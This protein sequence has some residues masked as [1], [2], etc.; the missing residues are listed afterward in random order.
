[1]KRND[2]YQFALLFCALLVIASIGYFVYQELF[3]EYKKYQKGYKK[4]EIFRSSYTGEKPA[5]FSLG[6]KQILLSDAKNGPETI[7]R[8]ISCHVAVDL[9]H[10]SKESP[11]YIWNK[12]VPENLRDYQRALQMHPLFKGESRPFEFHPLSE[13][14]CTSCHGGNGRSLVASRAHGPLY[15]GEYEPAYHTHKPEFLESDPANDPSFAQM[16]NAKPG[17]E[18]VFQ[19]TPLLAGPLMGA[20]CA[21]CHVGKEAK[22]DKLCL[23]YERGKELFRSQACYACHRISGYSRASIGPELT[24]AGFNYPWYIKESIVWP[25]A[26]LPSSTMPNFRLD[27]EEVADLM[28]FLM[29][30][31]GENTPICEA[32]YM[33]PL[34]KWE[35]GAKMPW[36]KALVGNENG[37]GIFT[38][39]GCAACHKLK[40]S[41]YSNK[42]FSSHFPEQLSGSEIVKLVNAQGEAIDQQ[43]NS[44]PLDEGIDHA[45]YSNFKFAERAMNATYQDE[46]EKLATYKTRLEKVFRAYVATYGIGREIAPPLNWSG[47]YR[48]DAWLMG[49]FL[50][51]MAYTPRSLMPVFPFDSSKFKKLSDMLHVYGAQNRD[52]L[53][54]VWK[55]N[56]FNPPLA[57]SLLCSSC[58]GVYRQGNGPIAEWIYPIPKNLKNPIFLHNLTKERAIDSILHGVQGTPMPPWGEGEKP[59]LTTAQATQL[60]D[61]LYQGLPEGREDYDKW[62]YS[63]ADFAEEMRRDEDYFAVV[64]NSTG[65]LDHELYYFREKYYTPENLKKGEE[66]FLVNCATCHGADGG[67][68]GLRA[69]AMIEAKPRMLNNLPWLKSR[70]DLRLLRSIK[71]G[72]P[73]TAMTPW[74]DMTTAEQRMQLVLFIRQQQ[75]DKK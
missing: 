26:D 54:E 1:M 13:Y 10:F 15:D 43:L 58:H 12:N 57:Y 29:A 19:T 74:G 22:V 2:F 21:Q 7:D 8:C 4:L 66:L 67:G 27:H 16:Y 56:G 34:R 44:L 33:I 63:A 24:Y 52:S 71:Y 42:W 69:T 62:S 40:T 3:P 17:H 6:I 68:N 36:E 47:V 72:V 28:A 55:L 61:W 75:K 51:P 5:P 14:G 73:G 70:D 50:N 30:Q 38:S 37:I 9:P 65:G 18:L 32:D 45:F 25:Q 41:T 59:V 39:E 23:S 20:K 49:H 53:Q 48:D 46:P 35:E 60:V 11:D 31:R 64:P